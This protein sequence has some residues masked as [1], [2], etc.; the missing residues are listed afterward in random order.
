MTTRLSE[1]IR[2]VALGQGL[3]DEQLAEPV[4]IRKAAERL[5]AMASSSPLIRAMAAS[6]RAAERPVAKGEPTG[7]RLQRVIL[8]QSGTA[9]EPKPAEAKPKSKPRT[10]ALSR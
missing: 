6:M 3:T 7:P 4:H 2:S 5:D 8:E 9:A 1:V 10:G